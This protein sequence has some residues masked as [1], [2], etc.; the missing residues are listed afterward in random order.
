MTLLSFADER[1][2]RTQAVALPV[3]AVDRGAGMQVLR[4]GM[5]VRWSEDG[6][7]GEDVEGGGP[8]EDETVCFFFA[9]KEA[10]ASGAAACAG[11]PAGAMGWMV[12]LR[13]EELG[14]VRDAARAV[15]FHLIV[16]LSGDVRREIFREVVLEMGRE[17]AL[18][19][20]ARMAMESVRRCPLAGACRMLV[21]AAR[22]HDLLVEFITAG[23]AR[24][25]A[26]M[27]ETETRVRAAAAALERRIEETPL[28]EA[29][30]CEA[31]LSETTLKRGFRQVFGTTVFEH[32]RRLRME[33]ARELLQSGEATVIE[34]ATMVGYSNPSNFASAFRRQFGMNPKE[35]QLAARR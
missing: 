12:A 22:C 28:L 29:L 24:P 3:C 17:R 14:R 11:N 16:E 13:R 27:S 25:T 21:L 23:E 34:A 2:S 5:T 30:A 33:S 31:G 1:A 7:C 15:A 4:P 26:L 10:R 32:L 35:F 8:G 9:L 19:A 20:A 6:L 18:T